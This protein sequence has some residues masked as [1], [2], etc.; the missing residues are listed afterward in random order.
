[1]KK[2]A[3]LT[4]FTLSLSLLFFLQSPLASQENKLR[5][6]GDRVN[7]YIDSNTSSPVIETAQKGDVLTLLSP[8]KQKNTWYY[9]SFF[10]GR[11]NMLVS[12][13][14]LDSSVEAISGVP[15]KAEAKE[16]SFEFPREVEVILEQANVRAKPN[17][18]S[19]VLQQ[20]K[21]GMTLLSI[22]KEG[23]WYKVTLPPD[24]Q[25]NVVIG[26][27]HQSFVE[28]LHKE[29]AAKAAAKE[30]VVPPAPELRAPK[31]RNNYLKAG[32]NYF[33]FTAGSRRRTYGNVVD[34]EAEIT[35][36]LWKGFQAW[37]GTS[38]LYVSQSGSRI[39]LFPAGAGVK[40]GKS[41]GMFN[42]YGGVGAN[43]YKY[44]ESGPGLSES[45][46]E[47]GYIA[48]LGSFVKIK[49]GFIVDLHVNYSYCYLKLGSG[50]VNIGGP[51][52]GI[53]LGYLF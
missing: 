1:M 21:V 40:Y 42:F 27:V 29:E 20:I 9:V 33:Q 32:S 7:I 11:R 48:K 5:V 30:Q 34:Y 10:S 31:A 53:C 45:K 15:E 38:Y 35:V 18:E 43:Y 6:V 2:Q 24:E 44:K 16:V 52:A 4:L 3:F 26:Y 51:E 41:L 28:P 23:E 12:G 50:N 8:N 22:A 13:F 47:V 36:S 14:V 37:L 49:W 19:Q 46:G 39:E 25:G 17:F